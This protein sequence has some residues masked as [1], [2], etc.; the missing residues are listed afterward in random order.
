VLLAQDKPVLAMESFLQAAEILTEDPPGEPQRTIRLVVGLAL[1]GVRLSIRQPN[2]ANAELKIVMRLC[3]DCTRAV[4]MLAQCDLE[5]NDADRAISILTN[6]L[7]K[8][9]NNPDLL[10]VL[11]QAKARNNDLKGARQAWT[12]AIGDARRGPLQAHLELGLLSI[13]E[14]N[15]E[16]AEHHLKIVTELDPQ[17]AY[18][19]FQL[20]AV[21]ANQKQD[22]DAENALLACLRADPD[23]ELA[24]MA[25]RKI[26][27]SE[28]DSR[29]AESL[30]ESARESIAEHWLRF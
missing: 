25:W 5:L 23:Q 12:A 28:G 11:G 30:L 6:A 2:E 14:R 10:I 19:W 27:Q 17:N 18:A 24:W 7:R 8:Q 1:A 3:E 4:V 15:W 26:K 20:A 21:Y 29:E 13:R 22:H 9:P 16:D